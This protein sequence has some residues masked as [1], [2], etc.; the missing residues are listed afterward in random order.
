M[1]FTPVRETARA[2]M[3]EETWTYFEGTADGDVDRDA[4]AWRR[5]DLVPRVLTG[6]TSIDT[7]TMIGAHTFASPVVLAP[8]ASQGAVHPDGELATRRAAA[9]AGMLVGYS[10]HATI[11]VER[12]AAAADAPWWAQA[13]VMED[14]GVSDAYLRR[15]AAAGAAAV[16]LT[17]DLPGTLSDPPWRRLRL[18]D[19]V[20]RRGN[21][22][23]E[24]PLGTAP[25]A[26]ACLGPDEIVRT[27]EVSGL[28]VW[29]KGVMTAVDA[30]L[31][32]DAGAAGVF[33]S[34][35]GRRQ[36]V[37]VAPTAAVLRDVV[38]GVAGRAPVIVDGGIRSGTDVVRALALGAS[39]A[40][41]GRPV[42]WAL[43]AGGQ[44]ALEGVLATLDD[45]VRV[46]MAGLGAA[47]VADIVPEMVRPAW[48]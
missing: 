12:F 6:L 30:R 17:V 5:W 10:Y 37:G 23:A 31:A 8:T 46:A 38:A 16:V 18:S 4:R 36:L 13:Y 39:A 28:P 34:N 24:Y 7:S 14:R 45:E 40:A 9:A 22:P 42:P 19:E 41:I 44:P 48:A 33:V 21:H 27:R 1:D 43:A 32:I 15:C 2:S 25:V 3:S 11:E 47:R 20:A 26:E 29:V 35:H